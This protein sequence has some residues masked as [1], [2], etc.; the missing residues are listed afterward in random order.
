MLDSGRVSDGHRRNPGREQSQP[1]VTSE[2]G[3]KGNFLGTLQAYANAVPDGQRDGT[4]SPIEQIVMFI[5]SGTRLSPYT[6]A[7]GNMKSAFPLP[8]VDAHHRGYTVGEAAIRSTAAC[9]DCL[10]GGG[11]DGL[12]V[13]WGDEILIPS[14][15]LDSSPGQYA[16][17]DVVRFGWRTEPNE[18]L[19]NQKEW[20][21]VDPATGLVLQEIGRQPLPSVR[22]KLAD[23]AGSG[24]TQTYVNLGSFAASNTFLSELAAVF[25]DELLDQ[26]SAANWDP[27]FWVA[28]QCT[29]E[30]EWES[31]GRE[32]D[33]GSRPGF[34][35]LHACMPDFFQVV[36]AAKRNLRA[37]LGRDLR[38]AILDFGEPYW[39]DA[40][41]HQSL[42]SAFADL[43]EDSTEGNTL[44][45]F[46][47]LPDELANGGS[48][49]K[50]SA[51]APGVTV[52]E[53]IVLGAEIRDPRS[54]V[55][56]AVVVRGSYGRLEVGRGGVA[57]WSAADHLSVAGPRGAAFRFS[58]NGAISGDQSVSTLLTGSESISM[59]YTE[60]LGTID[61]T[62]YNQVVA[63]NP[64]SFRDAFT[65][66]GLVD[67]L[68]LHAEWSRVTSHS[69]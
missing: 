23:L 5:G 52:N 34:R 4:G 51:L 56:G 64:M 40:G 66:M 32:E 22:R 36:Q 21:V 53:S 31:F 46:L 30:A 6:Q 49:V 26:V 61:S 69:A 48:F 20:L 65:R 68:D 60:A 18:L 12:V 24:N 33:A 45:A 15:P 59:R 55:D 17:V 16:D 11:F 38:I 43:F 54:V 27:Y 47:G 9:I 58:G 2:H 41:N 14:T 1:L 44:R 67:P 3:R 7:L 62:S 28:L 57:I 50:D 42:R 19:A 13:R 35:E 25:K 63:D 8:D 37:K 29:S 39:L 10:R